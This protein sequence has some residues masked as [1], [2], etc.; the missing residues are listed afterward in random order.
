MLFPDRPIT[1]AHIRDF[2]ARFNEGLRIE[3]KS[4]FDQNVRDNLP[5]MVSSFANSQGGVLVVGVNTH[6]GEP[7]PLFEGF[8]LQPRE[9]LPLTVENICLR[10]IH[11]PVLPRST[12]VASDVADRIFLII[13]VEESGEAPHAIE[14]SKKVYVRTGNA[15]NPYDLADVDLV[16]DL[17]KRRKEPLELRG[18]L[19]KLAEEPSGLSVMHGASFGQITICPRYRATP[20]VLHRRS[21]N[22]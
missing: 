2:C 8:P 9:E 21:G 5:K 18:R 20:F 7:Q 15:A 16:I 10:N 14:N 22:S 11:P 3:Y 19:V 6:R 12:V 4:N 13:E 17:M 1:L